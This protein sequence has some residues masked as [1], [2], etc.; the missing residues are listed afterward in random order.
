MERNRGVGSALSRASRHGALRVM[1]TRRVTRY[2][3][4]LITLLRAVLPPSLRTA[5]VTRATPPPFESG[6]HTHTRRASFRVG[7]LRETPP[8]P[9]GITAPT[10]KAPFAPSWISD[11]SP[12]SPNPPSRC[13]ESLFLRSAVGHTRRGEREEIV[14]MR[15]QHSVTKTMIH[16][17]VYDQTRIKPPNR[18]PFF[19]PQ[20]HASSRGF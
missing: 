6:A 11:T 13:V 19:G 4:F 1:H 17:A 14:C 18:P 20:P 16:D 10:K 5:R 3:A 7:P 2:Y 9:F 12:T 8:P 15:R